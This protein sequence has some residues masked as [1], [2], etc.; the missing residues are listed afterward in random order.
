MITNKPRYSL[1]VLMAMGFFLAAACKEAGRESLVPETATNEPAAV[2]SGIDTSVTPE[3]S[4]HAE[5]SSSEG[6]AIAGANREPGGAAGDPASDPESL[7]KNTDPVQ[8][9]NPSTGGETL[10]ANNSRTGRGVLLF[11]TSVV[12]SRIKSSEG[13]EVGKIKDLLFDPNDRRIVYAIVSLADKDIAVPLSAIKID[14]QNHNY[15]LEMSEESIARA[16]GVADDKKLSP[17]SGTQPSPEASESS[18]TLSGS[19]TDN[20][21]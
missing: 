5:G 6:S 16:P 15:T 17:D 19:K 8:E 18:S 1:L 11:G 2:P 9:A 20:P 4:R 7:P 12:G 14:P 10:A 21:S 13:T 3:Q